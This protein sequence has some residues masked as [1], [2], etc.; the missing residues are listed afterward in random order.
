MKTET[1]I[2]RILRT[3]LSAYEEDRFTLEA[4]AFMTRFDPSGCIDRDV[5]TGTYLLTDIIS[6]A[7]GGEYTYDDMLPLVEEILGKSSGIPNEASSDCS[8]ACTP[9][10]PP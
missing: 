8:A 9:P 3:N 4:R 5:E 10:Q 7:L 1:E 6:D 2:E